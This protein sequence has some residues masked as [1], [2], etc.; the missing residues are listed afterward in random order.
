MGKIDKFLRAKEAKN[1]EYYT[2]YEDV[3]FF[4]ENSQIKDY[5]ADKVVYCPC[6]TENSNIYKYLIDNKAALRIKEV[7]R[8]D[9]DYYGH[10][11]LYDKANIIF[12]NPPFTGI[13]KWL[14]WL[15]DQNIKYISWFPMMTLYSWPKVVEN[16]KFVVCACCSS[17]AGIN[18]Q[19]SELTITNT[20]IKCINERTKCRFDTPNGERVVAV[21]I[22]SNDKYFDNF[23]YVGKSLYK[24]FDE[25][26]DKL[27][28]IND[29][30]EVYNSMHIPN[31]YFDGY[32][33]IPMTAYIGKQRFFDYVGKAVVKGK[34]DK[35]R[36]RIKVKL[37]K[38]E[39][40]NYKR[41]NNK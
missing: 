7:L 29:G 14:T 16:N 1:N 39:I 37:K 34:D 21:Y 40:E 25:V 24:T 28:W 22:I 41:T 17:P 2:K 26:K 30:Y 35:M 31:D 23:E 18:D 13:K 15:N 36:P 3:K 12:S 11:D 20:G 5:L 8:S 27:F 4:V 6:D 38:D 10:Q 32:L 9:D 19:T 33:Y